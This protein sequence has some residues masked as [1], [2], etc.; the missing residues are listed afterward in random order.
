MT[1]TYTAEAIITAGSDKEK[2]STALLWSGVWPP[3]VD[4]AVFNFV[5]EPTLFT[6][7]AIP[8][9]GTAIGW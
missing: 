7:T 9:V 6:I 4:Q 1:T 8:T 2:S 3:R 5:S